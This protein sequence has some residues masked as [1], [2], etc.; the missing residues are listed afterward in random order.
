MS[1]KVELVRAGDPAEGTPDYQHA[2]SLHGGQPL[3]SRV[4]DVE[5][6][7]V[8]YCLSSNGFEERSPGEYL[9][10][11]NNHL[12]RVRAYEIGKAV[13]GVGCVVIFRVIDLD[14]APELKQSRQQVIELLQDA[15]VAFGLASVLQPAQVEVEFVKPG[16]G[17]AR[18]AQGHQ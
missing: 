17:T 1:F 3:F 5:R 15:F 12:T 11:F 7:G 4:V 9:L 18:T 10:F 13:P 16:R 8:L 6:E 2:Q 14:V